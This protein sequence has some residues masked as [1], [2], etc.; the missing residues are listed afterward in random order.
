M[1]AGKPARGLP[2]WFLF[3]A[4]VLIWASTWHVILYQLASRVPALTSV[5]WRF[6]LAALML[7]GLARWQGRSLKLPRQAHA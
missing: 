1:A 5:G 6:L 2:T 4:P 7:A 3:L